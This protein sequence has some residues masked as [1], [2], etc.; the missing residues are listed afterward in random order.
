MGRRIMLAAEYIQYGGTR[1]YVHDLLRFYSK[2]GAYVHVVSSFAEP[3]KPMKELVESFGF[4]LSTFDSLARKFN[5]VTTNGFPTVWSLK[6]FKKEVSLFKRFMD[7]EN[8]NSSVISVGTSGLFL[9]ATH[10]AKAPIMIAHGY[11]HGLRQKLFGSSFMANLLPK[12]LK[13]LTMSDY[14]RKAFIDS[15]SKSD[16]DL[17]VQTL[18]STCG[19]R[20]VSL[21]LISRKNLVLTAA[22]VEDHKRPLDWIEIAQK[23]NS[24][25]R[26][27]D[28]E[29]TWFG[30][31]PLRQAAI[32]RVN[33]LGLSGTSF[34]G[35]SNALDPHYES[36][37]VYLQTSSKESLGLSV[38][39]ALRFG[40]PA[41]VTAAGGLPE[42]VTDGVTGFV[43]PVGDTSAASA[44]VAE[45]LNN[46]NLWNRLSMAATASYQEKFSTEK[47]EKGLMNA[48]LRA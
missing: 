25:I 46:E 40:T 6:A 11:P 5:I 14:A 8:L 43:V 35:W 13:I 27:P 4:A 33:K 1:T 36:A 20:K 30:E 38:I 41:V 19:E 10:A 32:R 12:D 17:S 21:P 3:D 45:L 9:S 37:K 2:A 47:W 42:V 18:H 48:H 39:D 7:S 28:L 44:A 26:I 16:S 23:T 22:L 34:P 29:F 15:W 24:K 31:G